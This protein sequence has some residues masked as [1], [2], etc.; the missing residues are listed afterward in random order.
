MRLP[1]TQFAAS[2]LALSGLLYGTVSQATD[3]SEL[4]LKSS[5]YNKPNV[6]IG[7]DDSGSMDWEML[8]KTNQGSVWFDTNA[9]TMWNGTGFK[10]NVG[11]SLYYLFP[12]ANSGGAFDYLPVSGSGDGVPPTVQFAAMRSS[13]YNP[14]YY[15]PSITYHPWAPGYVTGVEKAYPAIDISNAAAGSPVV[16]GWSTPR[17]YN[18]TTKT[19]SGSSLNLVKDTTVQV[20][21]Y[22]KMAIPA[23]AVYCT[24]SS[25]CTP[26]T[27]NNTGASISAGGTG[28]MRVPYYPATYWV[29]AS[30][31]ANEVDCLQTPDGTTLKRKEIR[32]ANY[33]SAA[34]FQ[35]DIQNFA[36]WYVY[37]RKRILMMSGAMGRVME[38]LTGM[39]VGVVHFQ[40]LYNDGSDHT[41][42]NVVMYDL[43]SSDPSKNGL[44]VTGEFYNATP[45][46]STPT[47]EILDFIGKQYKRTDKDA[48]GKYNII[49]YSC[50]RNNAFITTD[51]YYNNKGNGYNLSHPSYSSST[52]GGSAPY[53]SI[54]SKS[55]ADLALAYY[56]INPRPS[57][58]TDGLTEGKVAFGKAGDNQD[59]NTNLHM[60]TY[61]LTLNVE[62]T[63]WPDRTDAFTSP[64]PSWPSVLENEANAIDDL[65]H[66]TVNGR[67]QI[68]LATTPEDTAAKIAAGLQDILDQVGS[69]GGVAVASINLDRSNDTNAYLASYN[70]A[71]WYGDLTANPINTTTGVV[72]ATSSWSAAAKLNA[73]DWTTRLIATQ[74]SGV[75]KA[76]TSANVGAIVN[77]DTAD[78]TNQQVVEYLRGNRAGEG[79][80]FRKR[81]GLM[82]AAINA[83]PVIDRDA[84]VAYLET[85]EGMLHA[86]D[87]D[88]T[89]G[90]VGQ[91]LWAF[92]PQV[93]LGATGSSPIGSTVERNYSF[94]TKLDGTPSIGKAGSNKLLVS[95]MGAA[96][97]GYFALDVTNP[98]PT[99]DAGVA[100]M[101]KWNFTNTAMG[102]GVGKPLIVDTATNGTVV[103]V[104]SGYDNGDAAVANSKKGYMWMLNANTGAV[105]KTFYVDPESGASIESGL[106]HV[107]AYLES[108]GKARYVYG[109]DLQG[110]LWR[111]D[112]EDAGTTVAGYKL[113]M[114]KDKYGNAQPVTTM[115][116]LTQVGDKRVVMV[117]TGRL[118]DSGDFGGTVYNSFYAIADGNTLSN[119]RDS[120]VD[121][122]YTRTANVNQSTVN[123]SSVS[124]TSKRGWF[125][126]LPSGEHDNTAPVI[127]YGAVLFVTNKNGGSNCEQSSYL[128]MLDVLSGGLAGKSEWLSTLIS[129]TV[130]ASRVVTLRVRNGDIIA[131]THRDDNTTQS[132]STA[133]GKSLDPTRNAW[134]EIV[135]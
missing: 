57:S 7:F 38:G 90:N 106:A 120:L 102:Y 5:V 105:I 31:T 115:P 11:E 122:G 71:G 47:R 3:L 134:K 25:S 48:S 26:G 45:N 52:W 29:K 32:P 132:Q 92:V 15:D 12:V 135:R 80:L 16:S 37:Y 97:R 103:L 109:G 46:R 95:G 55:L 112:L 59:K 126:D 66:A 23:G 28:N 108:N 121:R 67:G 72:S 110:R 128:Y 82:G 1:R 2:L 14:L 77:P 85:G 86:F 79:S 41:P 116:E 6:I 65:W 70:P 17:N 19:W 87:T 9:G 78:Y 125:I 98:R 43:D 119:A 40:D 111:F 76:F 96:G 51:G 60:N 94:K 101:V 18:G 74:V 22:K 127:A 56:T 130:G 68:Y 36:N 24:T 39:R 114:L 34:D 131:T 35:K 99:S 133:L 21:I 10:N 124:W 8:L 33:G 20:R 69:Q 100:S 104:T 30:C 93:T 58:A 113:A 89:G 123:N 13:E 81:T 4:P 91:E 49:Q 88:T 44:R 75:G 83:E 118:L 107:A 84:K 42:A 27:T 129:D 61:A 53:T 54:P 62:G 50:Q 117:G 63:L 64:Y 73:R